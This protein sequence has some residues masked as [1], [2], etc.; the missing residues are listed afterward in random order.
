M[1]TGGPLQI[2]HPQAHC[3]YSV[4]GVNSFGKFHSTSD[5]PDIYTRV[6]HYIDWIEKIV[7]P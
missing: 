2:N 3:M 6:S 4:I 7:W 5:T 1:N